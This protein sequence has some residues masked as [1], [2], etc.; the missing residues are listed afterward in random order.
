LSFSTHLF[1]SDPGLRA[2][3]VN[4]Q[5]LKEGDQLGVLTLASITEDGVVFRFEDYLVSVSVLD[6]WN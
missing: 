6:D 5:R 2:V 4:G 3:V 1:S